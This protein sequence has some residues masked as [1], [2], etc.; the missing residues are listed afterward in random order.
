VKI[1]LQNKHTDSAQIELKVWVPQM[2]DYAVMK[3][4]FDTGASKT[5]IDTKLAA[6]LGVSTSPAPDT[7]TA[8]GRV[9]TERG[10]VE[11]IRIGD[12]TI[13]KVPVNIMPLPKELKAHCLLGMNVIREFEVLMDNYNKLITLTWKPLDKKYFIENYSVLASAS[14]LED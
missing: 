7:L 13:S 12:R 3:C 14:E 10:V 4:L 2:S 5:V 9:K 11:K 6:L 1:V 8:A